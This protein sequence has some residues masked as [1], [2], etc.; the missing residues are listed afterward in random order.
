MDVEDSMIFTLE[1]FKKHITVLKNP[2]D[3]TNIKPFVIHNI[4]EIV[5][6][7]L[8]DNKKFVRILRKHFKTLWFD[9]LVYNKNTPH[10]N[11]KIKAL[12]SHNVKIILDD[13]CDWI[14]TNYG[15]D[16]FKKRFTTK[17]VNPILLAGT[18]I[19]LTSE[20]EYSELMSYIIMENIDYKTQ[21]VVYKGDNL[22]VFMS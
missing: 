21:S 8:N 19:S 6:F 12:S 2:P 7:L 9:L 4:K 20:S 13:V 5:I 18:V 11:H 22:Y 16:N 1:A 15:V 10:I 17:S 3:D 14:T